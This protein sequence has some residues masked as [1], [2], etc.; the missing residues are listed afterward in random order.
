MKTLCIGIV[1]VF[2]LNLTGCVMT[3]EPDGKISKIEVPGPPTRI[4]TTTSVNVNDG[5]GFR[6]REGYYKEYEVIPYGGRYGR[7]YPRRDD[8]YRRSLNDRWYR[9]DF[10]Y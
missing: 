6:Y 8:L 10:R 5:H 3:V 1:V 7:R 9:N 2:C 4:A